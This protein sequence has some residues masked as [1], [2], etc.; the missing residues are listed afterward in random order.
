MEK[1][2]AKDI[3]DIITA[4]KDSKVK[5][6][7]YGGLFILLTDESEKTFHAETFTP[8]PQMNFETLKPEISEQ[9]RLNELMMSNPVAWEEEIKKLDEAR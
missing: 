7:K 1:L 9:D 2:S 4:C 8:Q 6:I 5:K 3:C